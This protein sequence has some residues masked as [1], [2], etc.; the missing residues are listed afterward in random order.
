MTVCAFG[1]AAASGKASSGGSSLGMSMPPRLRSPSN[2][3]TVEMGATR[4]AAGG[5]ATAEAINS[6][7]L[8]VMLAVCGV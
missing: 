8:I 7:S 3:E 6:G 2:A 1:I 5:A 4:E